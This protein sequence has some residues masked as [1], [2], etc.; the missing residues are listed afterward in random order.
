MSQ[1]FD[2]LVADN[3]D[4]WTSATLRK[5]GAGRGGGKRISLYGIERL[6]T[7][8][9]DLAVRGKLVPQD[10]GDEPASELL[11]KI[12]KERSQLGHK[13]NSEKQKVTGDQTNNAHAAIP[14]GWITVSLQEILLGNVGGGTP[15]KTES[16]YWGGDIPWASVKDV[17]KSKFVSD[18]QDRITQL[19]LDKSSANLIPAGNIILVTRM[20]LGQLSINKIDLA[21][22]QDLRAIFISQYIDL[23]YCYNFFLTH[24]FEG[25]GMTVKGVKLP[26][27]LNT[28]FPLPPLAEQRR[29]VAKVDELMALCDALERGTVGA[30]AAH[31]H[32]VDELLATLVNAADAADLATNW[33]RLE[34]HF[35]TLFTTGASVES[36]KQTILGL[37]VRGKLV[38]QDA[39][40]E[41]A[42][43]LIEQTMA[44]KLALVKQGK[45]KRDKPLPKV[46]S[47]DAPFELPSGWAWARFP[48]LGIFERGKSKHRP[49]NDPKLFRPG[50]YPLVQTGE[51]ARSDGVIQEF[52]SEYSE[53][54]LAQSKLWPAGTLCITIAANIADV[55]TLG[56]DA[57]FPD[58]VVGF[59]PS[60]PIPNPQY[61]LYFMKTAKADLLKFAPSTAQKNINLGILETVLIPIPPLA[62]QQR[63]VAKVEALMALC[64]ALKARLADTAQTR[65]Y[66]ADAIVERAAA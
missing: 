66:L 32:L 9:L 30:M 62:E 57:C 7:L 63:I 2:G 54:G 43:E 13:T 10:A 25:S 49:R 64:D 23:D 6:R 29:I 20:G 21:I 40:D 15:S 53:M 22:N 60:K 24:N 33:A 51:V 17:G 41:A 59:I 31:T 48:E 5:S 18:T 11:K 65:C 8:I 34:R 39:V 16:R 55:A 35:D 61:F 56:F 38:E 46:K 28:R 27:L 1:P 14:S 58:S 37:A 42:S 26:D 50:I 19:G 4:I 3:L 52:H 44:S 12:A 36:L 45:A 47:S